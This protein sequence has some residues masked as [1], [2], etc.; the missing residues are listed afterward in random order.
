V[1]RGLS[2]LQK[3]IL[4]ILYER[5]MG[6]D[7]GAERRKHEEALA[8]S[9]YRAVHHRNWH[10][11]ADATHAELIGALYDWPTWDAWSGRARRRPSE[12]ASLSSTGHNFS[13]R[14]VGRKEYR[15]RTGSYHRAVRRLE[16]RGLLLRHSWAPQ[17]WITE[18]G[19]KVV[20]GAL[21]PPPDRTFSSEWRRVRERRR[22]EP[23]S[24]QASELR[25]L[26]S[27]IKGRA[28]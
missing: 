6:R 4:S 15:R 19:V 8:R 2:Q 20:E 16:E 22:S 14:A 3:D 12:G 11:A 17:L 13:P 5:R 7:F 25:R 27:E 9:S 18:E 28:S 23:S 21:A 26:E 24:A 1:G 10:M